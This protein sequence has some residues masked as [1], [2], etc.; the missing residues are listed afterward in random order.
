M[1]SIQDIKMKTTRAYLGLLLLLLQV[2]AP[3][4]LQGQNINNTSKIGPQGIEVNTYTGNVFIRRLELGMEER[5]LPLDLEFYYNS[6][7]YS[8]NRDYGLGWGFSFGMEY[9][10]DNTGSISILWQDGREDYYQLKTPGQYMAP[11][12]VFDQLSSPEAGKYV[13]RNKQGIQ[14]FFEDST[15]KKITRIVSPNNNSIQLNYTGGKLTGISTGSGRQF[16]LAYNAAGLLQTITDAMQSPA[17]M[18]QYQ[19]DAAGRLTIATDPHGHTMKYKYFTNGPMVSQTDKNANTVNIVY[20]E[21]FSARELIGCN[22]R[23]SFSYDTTTLSSVVTEY[24]QGA[25]N[26]STTYQYER[27]GDRIWLKSYAGNCCGYKVTAQYDEDGNSIKTTDAKGN[28]Y[29]YSY[30]SRGNI[31]SST[32][33]LGHTSRFTY[34]GSFNQITSFTDANGN[35]Y[36]FTYDAAGNL[37]KATRPDGVFS[38]MTYNSLGDMLTITDGRGAAYQLTYDNWGNETGISGPAAFYRLFETNIRGHIISATNALGKKTMYAYDLLD[39]LTGFTDALNGLWLLEYDAAGNIVSTTDALGRKSLYTYDASNRLVKSTT[40]LGNTETFE[41]D[42]MDN[43]VRYADPMGHFIKYEYDTKNNLVAME[44]P[45]NHRATFLYDPNGNMIEAKLANGRAYTMAYDPADRLLSVNDNVGLLYSVQYDANSNPIFYT[46]K[47]GATAQIEYDKMDQVKQITDPQGLT[48]RFTYD[49]NG[50]LL[51]RTDR[52]GNTWQ[53]TYDPLDRPLT[54]VNPNGHTLSATFDAEGNMTE[55]IDELN[56][57]ASYTYDAR[58]RMISAT[59]PDGKAKTLTYNAVS[60]IIAKTLWDGSTLHYGYDAESRMITKNIPGSGIEQYAYNKAGHL[61]QGKVPNATTDIT[62]DSLNR[63]IEE[64]TNNRAVSFGY[65]TP[66]RMMQVGYPDGYAVT[67][68]FDVR[69]NLQSIVAGGNQIAAYTYSPSSQLSGITYGNGLQSLLQ[70]DA[71]GRHTSLQTTLL[72][73]VQYEYDQERNL[74]GIKRPSAETF[75]EQFGF[76]EQGRLTT[77]R[78]GSSTD[79]ASTLQNH[80]YVYNAAQFRTSVTRNGVTETYSTNPINQLTQIQGSTTINRMYDANG[81]L[82]YD[83]NVYKTY[84]VRGRLLKDSISPSQ[85]ISYRYDAF[86]RCIAR[87]E[88]GTAIQYQ[89]AGFLQ[90][91]ARNAGDNTLVNRQ[92]MAAPFTQAALV[93]ANGTFYYHLN[94]QRSVDA[95]S[96]SSGQVVETYS[97][98]PFGRQTIRN[99]SGNPVSA[100]AIGNRFGFT[101]QEYNNST[102]YNHFLFRQY[103]PQ[104]GSFSQPDPLGCADGMNMYRYVYNNPVNYVDLYGLEGSPNPLEVPGPFSSLG[105]DVPQDVLNFL[106]SAG[107]VGG[108]KLNQAEAKAMMDFISKSNRETIIKQLEGLHK[109]FKKKQ[110]ELA[111]EQT[112]KAES[113]LTGVWK[114]Q[115]WVS[116]VGFG[117]NVIDLFY[118]IKKAQ[119]GPCP[120]DSYGQARK[121]M[122]VAT[123][124]FSFTPIG[125]AYNLFDYGVEII[126]GK[127]FTTRAMD[128]GEWNMKM[129]NEH[130]YWDKAN[131]LA[132]APVRGLGYL[133]GKYNISNGIMDGITNTLNALNPGPLTPSSYDGGAVHGRSAY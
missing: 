77:Y 72:P 124:I 76:D 11:R 38:Q 10:K 100:S 116:R 19:Y 110:L 47:T 15:H 78:Q 127:S 56:R 115:K 36:S 119:S 25:S 55:A 99:S 28:I 130:P 33:P 126:S 31:L 75:S 7:L 30:D 95:I 1:R 82:I 125:G 42:A 69:N 68:S 14:Y 122:D 50:N 90:L 54:A 58:N 129:M 46:N 118:K 123:S 107:F 16:T 101:G 35:V 113:K 85:V 3:G 9:K 66:N 5:D 49:A 45:G 87:E 44:A 132:T 59:L 108:N 121:N 131:A 37:T 114:T 104:T 117:L 27:H 71:T 34:E 79:P 80:S 84:D 62:Y 88:A 17:R 74:T 26:Q 73:G 43:L 24:V 2:S 61:I 6:V 67:K 63:I 96:S 32:N 89:Y 81:N 70:Y 102:G 106:N 20:Y 93:N 60:D 40:A 39:R 41:Y 112:L 83:G 133:D 64:K 91:E 111:A 29:T 128:V 22:K 94:P 57:K 18:W 120:G 65:Q 109:S 86:G 13:V 8:V 12:G 52:R 105:S 4:M 97:Y 21:G 98:D 103:A 23:M 53:F 51:S 92:I 48:I